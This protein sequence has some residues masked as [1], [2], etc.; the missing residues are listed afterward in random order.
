MDLQLQLFTFNTNRECYLKVIKNW[1]SLASVLIVFYSRQLF[2]ELLLKL[3]KWSIL[4]WLW[5]KHG[6]LKNLGVVDIAGSGGV[7][8]VGG[9]SGNLVTSH[10]FYM[11]CDDIRILFVL[12]RHAYFLKTFSRWRRTKMLKTQ[13]IL[14]QSEN[15]P[16][17]ESIYNVITFLTKFLLINLT[18]DSYH[19]HGSAIELCGLDISRKITS[20]SCHRCLTLARVDNR[21]SCLVRIKKI[22]TR[23][24]RVIGIFVFLSGRA[25]LD[26]ILR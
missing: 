13:Q 11:N 21:Y 15:N 4:G 12:W 14:E 8:L 26:V 22:T 6:F 3:W 10:V 9:T 18:L 1:V 17:I 5:G 2:F 25:H 24:L 20:L 7:H 23:C 19:K 16:I